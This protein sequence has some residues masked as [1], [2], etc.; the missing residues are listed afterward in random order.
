[1]K[2]TPRTDAARNEQSRVTGGNITHLVHA[3]FAERLERELN[4]LAQENADLKARML[5]VS[6]KNLEQKLK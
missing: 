1:M 2:D 3:T 4:A 6:D 5:L